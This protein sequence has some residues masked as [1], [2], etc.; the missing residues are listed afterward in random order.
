MTADEAAAAI[1]KDP[2]PTS[3]HVSTLKGWGWLEP[4]GEKRETRR[5]GQAQVLEL[6]VGPD[7]AWRQAELEL[8][9]S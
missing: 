6:V 4:T 7:T 9:G 1:G 8:E 2:Y 5:G 3:T